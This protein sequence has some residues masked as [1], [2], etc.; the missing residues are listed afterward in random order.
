MAGRAVADSFNGE[1]HSG[2]SSQM[3]A[4]NPSRS[5][6]SRKANSLLSFCINSGPVLSID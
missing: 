6:A 3:V 4:N 2:T 5:P 1:T